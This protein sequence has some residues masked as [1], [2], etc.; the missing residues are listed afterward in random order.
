M[1]LKFY[2]NCL[3]LI[4]FFLWQMKV[5]MQRAA[6]GRWNARRRPHDERNALVDHECSNAL[7]LLFSFVARSLTK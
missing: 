1:A 4:I 2:F 3:G 5:D 7:L 6:F